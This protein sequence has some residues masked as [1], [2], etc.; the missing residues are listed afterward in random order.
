MRVFW[1]KILEAKDCEDISLSWPI[2]V[3]EG[4]SQETMLSLYLLQH[5]RLCLNVH[6]AWEYFG[7]M[8]KKT[9]RC[10]AV[11]TVSLWQQDMGCFNS[12]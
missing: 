4:H 3:P 9:R 8:S 2:S 7:N 12:G 10:E 5:D 1:E 11:K 6:A